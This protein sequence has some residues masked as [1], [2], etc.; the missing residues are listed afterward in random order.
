MR[1]MDPVERGLLD[2]I[3]AD[4]T[5]DLKRLVYADWLEENN[6][7]SRAD[8]M[9]RQCDNP[10]RFE[11]MGNELAR[12]I[13]C[14]GFICEFHCTMEKWLKH[15]LA[16]CFEHPVERVVIVDKEPYHNGFGWSW[17]NPNRKNPSHAVSDAA[18]I[19]VDIFYCL[20]GWD[21][22]NYRPLNGNRCRPYPA[23]EVAKDALSASCIDWARKQAVVK[24]GQAVS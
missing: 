12:G 3:I 20:K 21:N 18:N 2:G 4:P 23:T 13:W 10:I 19:P 24:V 16:V 11:G 6:R 9:R 22:W 14:R 17:Y 5:D 7:A 15:G 8:R 1:I